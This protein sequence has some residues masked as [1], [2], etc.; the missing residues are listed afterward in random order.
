MIQTAQDQRV[1]SVH[2]QQKKK[3][4]KIN[5]QTDRKKGHMTPSNWQIHTKAWRIWN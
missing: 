4:I 3:K 2:S 5:I 1:V